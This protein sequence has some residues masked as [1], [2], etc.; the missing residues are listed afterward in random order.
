MVRAKREGTSLKISRN[1]LWNK[2]LWPPKSK[3]SEGEKKKSGGVGS[4]V[5]SEKK[6]AMKA[7]E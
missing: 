4:H 7:G 6:R 5:G 1:N 2:P 3:I